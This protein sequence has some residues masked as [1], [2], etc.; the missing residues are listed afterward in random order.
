MYLA[1]RVDDEY[2]G[3]GQRVKGVV[4]K[5]LWTD[6]EIA[7]DAQDGSSPS[8]SLPGH[9]EGATQGRGSVWGA[10]KRVLQAGLLRRKRN[11]RSPR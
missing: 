3:T 9:I 4:G 10:K 5:G 2:E 1:R 7:N 8:R 11:L 6:P